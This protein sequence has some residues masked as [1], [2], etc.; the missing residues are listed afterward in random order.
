MLACGTPEAADWCRQAKRC[1]GLSGR[2]C[3]NSG[4][5][6]VQRSHGEGLSV[7]LEH[8]LANHPVPQ[9]GGAVLLQHC[10]QCRSGAVDLNVGRCPAVEGI[11]QGSPQSH[12]HV[13]Q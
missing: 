1:H 7:R 9:E 5:G 2:R 12:S 11:H 3:K 4:L 6:G 13:F 10:L 8:I